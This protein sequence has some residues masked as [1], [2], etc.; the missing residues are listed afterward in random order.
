MEQIVLFALLRLSGTGAL[1]AGVAISLVLTYR[2]AGVINF[3]AGSVS[4]ICGFMFWA[5]TGDKFGTTFGQVPALI[6]SIITAA[7]VGVAMELV[8]FRPLRHATPLA[9]LV[10]TVGFLLLS[11]AVILL[12]VGGSPRRSPRSFPHPRSRSLPSRCPS[13][14]STWRES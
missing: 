14:I 6:L 11:Q 1:I 9:K 12:A 2:G 8:A 3:A 5:L 7:L 13:L 10:S 4:M